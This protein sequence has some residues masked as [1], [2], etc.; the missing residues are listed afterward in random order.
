[1]DILPE[2]LQIYMGSIDDEEIIEILYKIPKY[3]SR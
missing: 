1:L 2:G 3:N